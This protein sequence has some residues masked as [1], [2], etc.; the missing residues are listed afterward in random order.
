MA[1]TIEELKELVNTNLAD[2]SNIEPAEH[3][4]VELALI[5]YLETLQPVSTSGQPLNRGMITANNGSFGGVE[6]GIE[7]GIQLSD[8]LRHYGNTNSVSCVS[9]P[10]NTVITVNLQN[11]HPNNNYIVK[12]WYEQ[13]P[14]SSVLLQN[15]SSL[16]K[17]VFK[18]ISP[19]Q[20][21]IILKEW[22]GEVQALR[23]HF[24]TVSYDY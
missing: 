5:D 4:A 3:R 9:M 20:F 2:N 18:I 21:Q 12:S 14:T 24:E 17:N 6:V 13:V 23:L 7:L 8:R 16:G 11:S 15:G 22:T 1:L 10:N 19:S